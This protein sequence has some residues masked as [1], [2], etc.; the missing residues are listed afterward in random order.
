MNC[1]YCLRK[2]HVIKK[3]WFYRK[4]TRF[5]ERQRYFCF[6][7]RKNFSAGTG[8]WSYRQHRP[9][10]DSQLFNLVIS[11]VS[12]RRSARL[13]S[14]TQKTVAR[15]IVRMGKFAQAHHS[16]FLNRMGPVTVATF[17]DMET[18]EHSKCKPVSITVA[19]EDKS[20]FII[21]ARASQ[22]SA[23]GRLAKIALKRYGYRRDKR[24]K[25]LAFT[26]AAVSRVGAAEIILKS[27]K[28]P[29]YPKAVRRIIPRAKHEVHLSRRACVVGQG[30]LKVGG[31][32]PLFSLNHTCAMFRDNMKRLTRKTWCT[33]KRVD[34]LQCLLDI[35]TVYH[36]EWIAGISIQS[37][38]KNRRNLLGFS[39]MLAAPRPEPVAGAIR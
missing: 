11:G 33:T 24:R 19:V 35:Y 15:K 32:D 23:K 14:T 9:D 25:G 7:C 4:N 2:T 27:D 6:K 1:P 8:T 20:R 34:R 39:T 29:R 21:A 17:D 31:F 13:L 36:N 16:E 30:E 3:G 38:K 5:K 10:L 28:C 22:M 18:F 26:L 12:Q 37:Q